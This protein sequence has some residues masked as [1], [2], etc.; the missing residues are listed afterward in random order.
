MIDIEYEV[1]FEIF[2][3][4]MKTTITS[5]DKKGI[6]KIIKDKIIFHKIVKKCDEPL[7]DDHAK[8]FIGDEQTFTN[9]KDIFGMK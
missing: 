5:P 3:K 1:Y 8:D 4:K 7:L 9:L 2:G 6:K